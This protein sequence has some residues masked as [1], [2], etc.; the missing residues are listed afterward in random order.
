LNA[1]APENIAD[2]SE[3]DARFQAA[4]SSLKT[5]ALENMLPAFATLTTFHVLTGWLKLE[6]PEKIA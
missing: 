4:T 1:E 2:M 6:A 5:E 3:T